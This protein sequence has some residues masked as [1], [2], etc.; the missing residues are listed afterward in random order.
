MLSGGHPPHLWA[1]SVAW[2]F[3]PFFSGPPW[4]QKVVAVIVWWQFLPWDPHRAELSASTVMI[5]RGWCS[6]NR[7]Q[8]CWSWL[9]HAPSIKSMS[10]PYAMG[11]K[12]GLLFERPPNGCLRFVLT[13]VSQ[14][15]SWWDVKKMDQIAGSYGCCRHQNQ[16]FKRQAKRLPYFDI[17]FVPK[18]QENLVIY[19]FLGILPINILSNN[20]SNRFFSAV[21]ARS[22]HW[23]RWNLLPL[24]G[25]RLFWRQRLILE[26]WADTLGY[27][28]HA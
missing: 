14:A 11:T 15:R 4:A 28:K 19:F 26:P 18:N 9:P 23:H 5:K 27:V 6:T 21:M 8:L 17:Y 12:R 20:F 2:W 16:I 7:K 24:E 22:H 13:F 3:S 10:C 25:A 1:M